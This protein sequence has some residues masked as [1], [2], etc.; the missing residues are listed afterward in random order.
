MNAINSDQKI[1]EPNGKNLQGLKGW[2]ILVG[3][4]LILSPIRILVLLLTLHLPIFTDGTWEAITTVGSISY[5]PLWGP[6]IITEVVYNLSMIAFSIFLLRI[7]L[8][9]HFLFPKYFMV[10]ITIPVLFIPIDAWFVT[11]ILPNQPIFDPD[12]MKEITQA[13]L[14]FSLWVPYMLVSKRVK[15]TFIEKRPK[16]LIPPHYEN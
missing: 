7:D 6:L 9:K 4:G 2:L 15:A 5:D 16:E 1:N 14:A 8:Q 12:T 3:L 13:V 10:V 11:L